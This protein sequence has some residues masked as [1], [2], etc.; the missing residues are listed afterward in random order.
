[1]KIHARRL[2]KITWNLML[3]YNKLLLIFF[4]VKVEQ[5]AAIKID[6]TAKNQLIEKLLKCCRFSWSNIW[7]E[8][9]RMK[10]YLSLN[11]SSS[12]RPTSSRPTT[13]IKAVFLQSD[14]PTTRIKEVF[15][16]SDR[17]TT[18]LRQFS[19]RYSGIIWTKFCIES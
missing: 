9:L 6:S 18:E 12:A 19:Y 1:M 10:K 3:K 7:S 15:L 2:F 14:R 5:K 4:F 8:S 17:P 13:R 16:Q 11:Q